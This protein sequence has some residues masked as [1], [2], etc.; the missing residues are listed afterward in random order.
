MNDQ[1]TYEDVAPLVGVTV[2]SLRQYQF[3]GAMPEP[4][5]HVGRTPWWSRETIEKWLAER[6]SRGRRKQ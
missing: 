2:A 4:D 1:L 5:G 6:P 3:R